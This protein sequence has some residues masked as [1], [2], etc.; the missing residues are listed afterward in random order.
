MKTSNGNTEPDAT[1][2][3]T[4]EKEV[5]IV[6]PTKED[7][8]EESVPD[9]EGTSDNQTPLNREELKVERTKYWVS[10]L[11]VYCTDSADKPVIF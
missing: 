6:L 3:S 2:S 4:T 5:E 9:D 11:P 1:G 10:S 8:E 7:K